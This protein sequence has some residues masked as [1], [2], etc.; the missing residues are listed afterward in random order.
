MYERTSK[1]RKKERKKEKHGLMDVDTSSCLPQGDRRTRGSRGFFQERINSDVYY[2]SFFPRTIREWNNLPGNVTATASLEEFQA[3]QTARLPQ[4]FHASRQD[5]Q[6]VHCFSLF[7]TNSFGTLLF[8]P[9][10]AGSSGPITPG[11][12]GRGYCIFLCIRRLG[13]SI[14][15]S[16][17]KNQKFEK[18]KKIYLKFFCNPK[19][20]PILYIYLKKR[21]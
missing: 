18:K 10:I 7:L 1:D 11:G 21:P 3:S 13:P 12:R 19:N 16:H 20:I 9:V 17:K 6:I 5:E 2:N 15:R 4:P 14:Y 8:L